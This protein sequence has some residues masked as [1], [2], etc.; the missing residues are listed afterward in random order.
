[1]IFQEKLRNLIKFGKAFINTYISILQNLFHF[2]FIISLI[3]I[4]IC[5]IFNG[6]NLLLIF[7]L[8]IFAINFRMKNETSSRHEKIH[9]FH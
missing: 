3:K 5:L 6:Q 4:L 9:D 1:M 8:F 7:Y 2:S